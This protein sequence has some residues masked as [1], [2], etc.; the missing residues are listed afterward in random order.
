MPC[1][2]LPQ[3]SFCGHDVMPIMV[4]PGWAPCQP[5][6]LVAEYREATP[7]GTQTLAAYPT[8]TPLG[9]ITLGL[10]A[11]REPLVVHH[12]AAHGLWPVP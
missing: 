10:L 7:S 1:L 12:R 11:E 2:Q 3:A 4:P 5:C 8:Y 6:H 9:L